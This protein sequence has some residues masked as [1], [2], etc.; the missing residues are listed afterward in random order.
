MSRSTA[1]KTFFLRFYDSDQAQIDA[2]MSELKQAGAKYLRYKTKPLTK[3]MNLIP[4]PNSFEVVM[5]FDSIVDR[6][7]FQDDKNLLDIYMKHAAKKFP[8]AT[9][10]IRKPGDLAYT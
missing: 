4:P 3:T 2:C 6:Q 5:Y 8:G 9:V 1:P 7:S 10:E